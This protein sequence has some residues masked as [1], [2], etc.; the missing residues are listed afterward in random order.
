MLWEIITGLISGS[1]CFSRGVLFLD[2]LL[3]L[4][5]LSIRCYGVVFLLVPGYDYKA[6]ERGR[7]SLLSS[8]NTG[9][10]TKIVF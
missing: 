7:V 2:Y 10:F 5:R 6:L 3:C 4:I 1:R 9:N 8:T